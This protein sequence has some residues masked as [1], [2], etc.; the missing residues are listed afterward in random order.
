MKIAL[1]HNDLP[2]YRID[3]F[4]RLNSK[5]NVDIILTEKK[6]D[7]RKWSVHESSLSLRKNS[8]IK[9]FGFWFPKIKL[10]KDFRKKYKTIICIDSLPFLLSNILFLLIFKK[11]VILWSAFHYQKY[12]NSFLKK[13]LLRGFYKFFSNRIDKLISYSKDNYC[14]LQKKYNFKNHVYGTQGADYYLNKSIISNKKSNKILF[15]G[16]VREFP[17]K[18]LS[19][20][21]DFIK[22]NKNYELGIIGDGPK[23]EYY[24]SKLDT[25]HRVIFYGYADGENKRKI[26]KD[27][28]LLVLPSISYEPWGWVIA[29]ALSMGINVLVSDNVMSKEIIEPLS[30]NH[31]F[32]SG[33]YNDFESKILNFK[34]YDSKLLLKYLNNYNS[35]MV[36]RNFEILF[37]QI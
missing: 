22:R 32:K 29:E 36:L 4:K 30:K 25:N 35:K 1:I 5:Y 33:N 16:Y 27:Y 18:G 2:P 15:I 23:L 8:F 6:Q 7:F 10:I 31:I 21:I 19:L 37:K 9:I 12:N 26:M 28:S 11:K 24:K 14:S 17:N 34:F 13:M 20:L 3:F